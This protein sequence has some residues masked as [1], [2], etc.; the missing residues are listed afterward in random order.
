VSEGNVRFIE[1]CF[2]VTPFGI[3]FLFSSFALIQ[4]ALLSDYLCIGKEFKPVPFC[5]E[6][7]VPRPFDVP[8]F[9]GNP[10]PRLLWRSPLTPFPEH[11]PHSVI[12]IVEYLL[13]YDCSRI[14]RPAADK[15]IPSIYKILLFQCFRS[16]D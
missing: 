13:R 6:C 8:V 16:F 1:T 3:F 11:I 15:G 5:K 2:T 12:H 10:G 9:S 14:V 7:P 4:S